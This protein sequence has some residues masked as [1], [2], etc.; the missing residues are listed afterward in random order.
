MDVKTEKKQYISVLS[1]ISCLGVVMMHVNNLGGSMF[2]GPH[3]SDKVIVDGVCYF[4]VP[5]FLMISGANLLDYRKRYDTKTFFR[6]RFVKVVIPFLFWSF[7]GMLY[8][9]YTN[10]TGGR[11][12]FHLLLGILNFEYVGTFWFFAPLFMLYL[13]MPLFSAVEPK[14]GVF[15]YLIL[16]GLALNY[17]IPWLTV[18]YGIPYYNGVVV[19]VVANCVILILI[20]YYIDHY[21]IPMMWRMIIYVLGIY[22][23][24][25]LTYVTL[26]QSELIGEYYKGFKDP[27]GM[28]AILYASAIFLALKQLENTKA[29][30]V[31]GKIALPLSG[32]TFGV[33][34]I[35]RGFIEIASRVVRV[36]TNGLL[37]RM[38]GSLVIFLI[39]VFVVKVLQKIPL[40]RR[41]VP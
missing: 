26:V 27:G 11:T 21:A 17:V 14:K 24:W 6:K 37:Y 34:L 12:A 7:V 16:A 35:H 9:I 38:V 23:G 41:I 13:T 28:M 5:V 4:A 30:Q 31:M 36:D 19:P 15:G 39:S 40:I 3:W 32:A 1:V 8:Y 33:Y 29:M 2:M 18:K 25:N 22:G 20:G 10:G